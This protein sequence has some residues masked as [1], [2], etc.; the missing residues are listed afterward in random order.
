MM[1]F[2]NATTISPPKTGT[3]P[4]VTS[5]KYTPHY[6]YLNRKHAIKKSLKFEQ[7]FGKNIESAPLTLSPTTDES[8]GSKQKCDRLHI[9]EF[10]KYYNKLIDYEKIIEKRNQKINALERELVIIQDIVQG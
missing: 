6:K 3:V 10:D 4:N 9:D 2:S 5:S 8:E 1:P 7:L